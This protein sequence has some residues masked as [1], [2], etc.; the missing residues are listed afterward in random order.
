M[1]KNKFD[2]NLVA[3]ATIAALWSTPAL[4]AGMWGDSVPYDNGL[5][6]KAAVDFCETVVEVH[7]GTKGVGQLWYR[8]GQANRSSKTITWNNSFPYDNGMNPSVALNCSTV[9][10]V[11]NA[12]QGVG[13]LW[14]RVG[15]VD[16]ASKTITWNKSFPYDNGMN[17]SVAI[18]GSTV[19]EVHNATQGVGPLWYRVGQ[20]DTASKTIT[21]NKSFPYDN[22][23]NP[24][25]AFTL[26]SSVL[27]LVEVHNGGYG[28]APLWSHI[29]YF[30]GPSTIK[31][32]DGEAYDKGMNP[33][34]A[35]SVG[36]GPVV[37]VHNGVDG[38]GQ[39]WYRLAYLPQ[40][41]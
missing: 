29:G 25:V 15:Q 26:S 7:N 36:Y 13:P 10:E 2:R 19:V 33:C 1:H 30:T 5:N 16:T 35:A 6:P 3:I 17:P 38:L 18:Y 32:V 8:V 24:T 20:V 11:H 34:V 28:V 4:Y 14:Y 9:V 31:W 41:Q 37:E 39:L 12:T 21:W 40:I 22:G 27:A 23:L